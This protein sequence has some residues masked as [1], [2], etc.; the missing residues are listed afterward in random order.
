MKLVHYETRPLR[1]S[2]E[3]LRTLDRTLV[4]S[5]ST[6]D[7]AEMVLYPLNGGLGAE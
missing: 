7:K 2:S 5:L 4:L 1:N 6:P 3:P